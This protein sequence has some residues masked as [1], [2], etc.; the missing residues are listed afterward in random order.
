MKKYI[1]SLLTFLSIF[2]SC[3]D[4]LE[5]KPLD[6]FSELEVWN[7]ASLAEGFIL[8]T[9]NSIVRYNYVKC[10]SISYADNIV[11]NGD[12]GHANEVQPKNFTEEK[13]FNWSEF[14]KIRRCNLAIQKL[15][16]NSSIDANICDRLIA[17]AKMLRAMIYFH[18][19]RKFGGYIIVKDVLKPNDDLM[20]SRATERETYDFIEQDITDAIPNLPDTDDKYR[21]TQASAHAL[22]SLVALQIGD[23]DKVISSGIELEKRFSTLDPVYNNMFNSYDGTTGSPEVIFAFA[24][25][26]EGMQ[27][28][29]TYMFDFLQ[30]CFNGQK[31]REDAVPQY[32]VDDVFDA[33]PKCWPSQELIDSYAF[34]Q[35]GEAVIKKGIDNQG[36]PSQEFWK[37][38]DARFEQSIVHDNSNFKRSTFTYRKGGNAHWTSNPLSTWG[39]SKTGYMFRK[40]MYENDFIFYNYPVQ[41]AEPILRLGEVYLNMS[42]AYARKG[43]YTNAVK[44]LNKTRVGHGNLP[45]L[46]SNAQGEEF[47]SWYKIERR[48]E[49]AVEDD[50]YWSLI[51]WARAEE[52]T[53][54]PE[55]NGYKLHGLDMESDGKINVV[56]SPWANP[57]KFEVPKNFF[58]PIPL[59]EIRN[60][61]NLEQNPGWNN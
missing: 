8:D 13:N 25:G 52:A 44:Y 18:Q 43:D 33:W 29:G 37:N 45:A 34:I 56:E 28:I 2:T 58:F 47:W 42:E 46:D 50:R 54:I 23:Y 1:I 14:G 15:T 39:M 16:D 49:L 57:M 53:N 51:R 4:A 36:F 9:Y 7:D 26:K 40:W 6:V 3:E 31:L 60:N 30:N 10:P 24:T 32:H 5:K 41:Y 11:T 19:A 61:E 17:E 20:L 21:F 38:R 35:D 22:M 55:L 27:Y 48:V 59:S 12:N